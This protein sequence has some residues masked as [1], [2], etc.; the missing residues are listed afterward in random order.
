[1]LIPALIAL[2]TSA[3]AIEVTLAPDKDL[4]IAYP[5]EPII[6]Q[7]LSDHDERVEGYLTL[8]GPANDSRTFGPIALW[9]N[10]ERWVILDD[11]GQA[12][13]VYDAELALNGTVVWSGQFA[14]THSP[15]PSVAGPVSVAVSSA[16]LY[17]PSVM[18]HTPLRTAVLPQSSR[19]ARSD[20]VVQ[21]IEAAVESIVIMG[22]EPTFD[23]VATNA[24]KAGYEVGGLSKVVFTDRLAPNVISSLAEGYD[25]VVIPMGGMVREGFVT[26]ELIATTCLNATLRGARFVGPLP[27]ADANGGEAFVFLS[28]SGEWMLWAWNAIAPTKIDID[29]T[30]LDSVQFHDALGNPL[31]TAEISGQSPWNA[32]CVTGKGGRIL[33]TA[34]EERASTIARALTELTG[35]NEEI[36]SDLHD[37]AASLSGL[38]D[39]TVN[40]FAFFGLIRALPELEQGRA[41][42][43]IPIAPAT[44]GAALIAALSRSLAVLEQE[45]GAPFLEPLHE[46]IARCVEF[47]DNFADH[48]RS[49]RGQW[50]I[51]EVD[52]LLAE[53]RWLDSIARPIE[54]DAVASIAEWRARSLSAHVANVQPEPESD[55]TPALE[56]EEGNDQ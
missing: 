37:I 49:P 36:P 50:L 28:R 55:P 53:A 45:N 17:R 20:Y 21:M 22:A 14:R 23:A 8:T 19:M 35:A 1:M 30:V 56:E 31:A 43:S 9:A 25:A 16:T 42:G 13:G 48:A 15:R 10:E 39:P 11:F 41:L 34:A 7:L 29:F 6:I 33:R 38:D 4:P 46:T 52:R 12:F 27:G 54:A 24:V 32:L 26:D 44:R 51:G 40:R 18:D 5:G 47:R 3:A 2:A